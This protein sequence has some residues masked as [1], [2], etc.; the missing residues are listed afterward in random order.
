MKYVTIVIIILLLSL[1]LGQHLQIR[2]MGE[3]PRQAIQVVLIEA[4]EGV[5]YWIR[6]SL[7]SIDGYTII[8]THVMKDKDL[9]QQYSTSPHRLHDARQSMLVILQ[10]K[11]KDEILRIMELNNYF[12]IPGTSEYMGH[13]TQKVIP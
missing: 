8:Y 10:D 11:P 5:F 6:D 1:A 7:V 12:F 13:V 4:K 3:N 9:H 2:Q